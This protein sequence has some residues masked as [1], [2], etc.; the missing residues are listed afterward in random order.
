MDESN[1]KYLIARTGSKEIQRIIK[2]LG[3]LHLHSAVAVVNHVACKLFPRSNH[4]LELQRWL[5]TPAPLSSTR[6]ALRLV[7]LTLER[8]ETLRARRQLGPLPPDSEKCE[9]LFN[10]LPITA[11][12][13]IYQNMEG[14]TYQQLERRIERGILPTEDTASA[15]RSEWEAKL[16]ACRTPCYSAPPLAFSTQQQPFEPLSDSHQPVSP[17]PQCAFVSPPPLPYQQHQLQQQAQSPPYP[18]NAN[19]WGSPPQQAQNN[20]RAFNQQ[21]VNRTPAPEK[22]HQQT[23]QQQ[24]QQQP[25]NTQWQDK[26]SWPQSASKWPPRTQQPF[27]APTTFSTGLGETWPQ[28]SICQLNHVA[29]CFR[30]FRCAPTPC[31]CPPPKHLMCDRCGMIGHSRDR[32][33]ATIHDQSTQHG[34]VRVVVTHNSKSGSPYVRIHQHSQ[35]A[36]TDWLRFINRQTAIAAH[37]TE[38]AR[39]GLPHPTRNSTN[40]PTATPPNSQPMGFPP[41]LLPTP[42]PTSTPQAAAAP[43]PLPPMPPP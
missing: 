28:C 16:M 22:W 41:P 8:L 9:W 18:G 11:Q 19:E 12:N 7:K 40:N 1:T 31:N 13:A 38:L 30:C 25:M 32:C 3:P 37:E 20:D 15:P 10:K 6:A 14:W 2:E 33:N 35:Q 29:R 23:Q 24:P 42:S 5:M 26:K 17:P 39:K 21:V 36:G 27:P 34:D 43:K 4:Y